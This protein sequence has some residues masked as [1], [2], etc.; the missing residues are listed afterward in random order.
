MDDLSQS[1]FLST[2]PPSLILNKL[3]IRVFLGTSGLEPPPA[4]D[5]PK[6]VK[7]CIYCIFICTGNLHTKKSVVYLEWKWR[8]SL[9]S[10]S[11][12]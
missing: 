2:Y 1:D 4:G 7:V 6:N 10:H 9:I 3:K 8:N 11:V 12:S 5:R